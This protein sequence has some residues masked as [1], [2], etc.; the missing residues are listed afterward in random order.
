MK[1]A[2]HVTADNYTADNALKCLKYHK[3]LASGDVEFH[4]WCING[5]SDQ[6]NKLLQRDGY[7]VHTLNRIS[8]NGSMQHAQTIQHILQEMNTSC[9]NVVAD[10][11]TA[12]L[13]RAWDEDV[14]ELH[15]TYDCV[16][17]QNPDDKIRWGVRTIKQ[18]WLGTPVPQWISMRP[19]P[20]W[21]A[22][23]PLPD[24]ADELG[25][26]SPEELRE[27]FLIKDGTDLARDTMWQIPR[28]LKQNN[29][30]SFVFDGPFFHQTPECKLFFGNSEF[31][32][33]DE[34]HYKGVPI[35]THGRGSRN[36][37]KQPFWNAVDAYVRSLK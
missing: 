19:G 33:E 23:N 25:K 20:T 18:T 29:L 3:M 31:H 32:T 26:I 16:G 5:V 11:D 4:A 12:A 34:F 35:F 37:S 15:K 17:I 8:G 27:V 22:H 10:G 28:F 13:K 9:I 21:S 36:R 1:I 14:R 6:T 7:Q 2:I 30:S 24:K